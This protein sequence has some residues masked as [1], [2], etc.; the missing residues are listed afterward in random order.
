M[1]LGEVGSEVGWVAL[2]VRYDTENV[3][4]LHEGGSWVQRH[5]LVR[6]PA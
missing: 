5:G 3:P 2:E 6:R 4:A 1:L